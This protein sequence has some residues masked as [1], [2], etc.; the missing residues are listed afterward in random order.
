MRKFSL[1]L[2]AAMLLTTGGIFANDSKIDSKKADPDKTISTQI[3]ELLDDNSFVLGEDDLT[4][5][6][7]FMLNDQK[8]IVVLSVDTE[9]KALEG[10]VKSRLNYKRVESK[11]CKKGE[12][13][14]VPVRI[15]ES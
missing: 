1:V 14:T 7:K 6:V 8:E 5:N 13:Y 10:F 9:D 2:V 3:A 15:T 12:T 11:D 4:A